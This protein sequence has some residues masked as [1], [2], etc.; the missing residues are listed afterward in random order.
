MFQ[1][2]PIQLAIAASVLSFSRVPNI[3]PMQKSDSS[4]VLE[5]GL[6]MMNW[7]WSVWNNILGDETWKI[8]RSR[9]EHCKLC[10]NLFQL[11]VSIYISI[12]SIGTKV[13]IV[14]HNYKFVSI[15]GFI[16]SLLEVLLVL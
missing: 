15:V 5:Y 6:G 3:F 14:F 13:I 4:H 10:F 2:H 7:P 12:I 11:H 1:L 8:S 9:D 16:S